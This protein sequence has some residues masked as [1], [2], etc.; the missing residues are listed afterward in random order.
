MAKTTMAQLETASETLNAA[1]LA[2]FVAA[3]ELRDAFDNGLVALN[4]TLPE[5]FPLESKRKIAEMRSAVSYFNLDYM[6]AANTP[7]PVA[8]V[9]EAPQA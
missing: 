4:D 2:T 7:A 6:I 8:P 3:K 9:E 1:N 5:N